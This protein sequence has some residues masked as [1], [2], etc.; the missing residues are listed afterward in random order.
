VQPNIPRGERWAEELQGKHLARMVEATE[1]ALAATGK[2]P[3]AILWPE[4]FLTTPLEPSA[5]L[6]E[7]LRAAVDR[8]GVPVILGAVRGAQASDSDLY[9]SS[10]LWVD[11][12]RGITAALDKERGVP[13]LEAPARSGAAALAARLLGAASDGKR[14]EEVAHP[15]A[16]QQ[17][18]PSLAPVLCYE[19]LFPGIAAGRRGAESVAIA[20]LADDGWVESEVAT[21]Q[22]LAFARFR[23]IEQRLPLVRV[24]HGGLSAGVDP[25]G[26]TVLELPLDSWAH[27]LAEVRAE[28][29][30]TSVE[31][32]ALL[33]LPLASG[34]GVGWLLGPWSR[35]GARPGVA[36]AD[37][38]SGG[39][40][41][42]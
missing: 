37:R 39:G 20:N 33:A 31:R 22:L 3:D 5:P 40:A 4:N 12:S 29:P 25:F 38:A 10:V 34:A 8:L 27:G 1:R 19:A 23:A 35:R 11:P 42:G 32:L 18:R 17:A 28:P 30:P 7:A 14:V 41:H 36:R 13:L 9:R 6:G 26:Q 15:E 24:A 21:R 16:S 2:A